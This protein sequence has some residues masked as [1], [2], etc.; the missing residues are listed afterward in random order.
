MAR[1]TLEKIIIA[2]VSPLIVAGLLAFFTNIGNAASKDELKAAKD[3]LIK[4]TDDQLLE[5]ETLDAVRYGQINSTVIEMKDR[6]EF[7]YLRELK[8]ADENLY[9]KELERIERSK[10]KNEN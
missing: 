8:K 7:L 3:E 1:S 10:K 6:V 4:Y 9:L 2:V 5:H